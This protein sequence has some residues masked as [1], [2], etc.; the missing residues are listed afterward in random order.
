MPEVGHACGHNL[1]AEAGLAAAI[2]IKAAMEAD[3]TIRGQLLVLGT[4]AE[5]SNGGKIDLIR[6]GAFEGVAAAMMVHPTNFTNSSP[7]MLSKMSVSVNFKGQPAHAAAFP[8]QGRNALDA[9]VSAYT[10]IAMLR[11]QIKSDC[12]VHGNTSQ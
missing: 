12:R 5:E 6:G 11:Q 10:N 4:P 2:G 3:A 8:W 9:A 7:Q 1:I